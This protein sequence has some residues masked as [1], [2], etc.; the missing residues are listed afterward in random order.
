MLVLSRKQGERIVVP[1]CGLTI[2]VLEILGARV[3]VG[4]AAP[5]NV[6]ILR[7]EIV[8]RER[9]ESLAPQGRD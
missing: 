5:S 3:R 9:R 4:I 2:T 7:A 6:T 8:E 1:E